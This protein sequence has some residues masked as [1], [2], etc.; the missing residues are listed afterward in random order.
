MKAIVRNLTAWLVSLLLVSQSGGLMLVQATANAE[1]RPSTSISPARLE[2]QLRSY[3]LEQLQPLS[4]HEVTLTVRLL[5]PRKPVP[6]RSPVSTLRVKPNPFGVQTG[7]RAF[8]IEVVS[9]DRLIQNIQIVADVK[10]MM[11]V[12]TPTRWIR[13]QQ[14]LTEADVTMRRVALSALRH[15][16]VHTLDQAVGKTTIRPLSPNQPISRTALRLPPVVRKGDR[17]IIQAKRGGLLVQA[18]GIAK[19]PGGLGETIPV[20]NQTS[21]REVLGIVR[22]AGLVEVTF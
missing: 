2:A 1:P 19:R 12:V 11:D 8:R 4:E 9:G 5:H 10:A 15:D 16:F 17:V 13:P 6:V 18:V 21:G 20:Q 22:K 3:L 14:L 7:R